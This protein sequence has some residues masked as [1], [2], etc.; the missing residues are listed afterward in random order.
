MR[1]QKENKPLIVRGSFK[2]QNS[3]RAQL[4]LGWL[5]GLWFFAP[6]KCMPSFTV[7]ITFNTSH[8]LKNTS[9]T[10]TT[11]LS[12][13]LVYTGTK[14][15]PFKNQFL[16]Q[17]INIMFW[18]MGL[19]FHQISITIWDDFKPTLNMEVIFNRHKASGKLDA[20]DLLV[21][22]PAVW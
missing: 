21:Q 17:L 7:I 1:P 22:S 3:G 19:I 11:L 9:V 2:W 8:W 18:N 14:I 16:F 5:Q 20:G 15:F 10:C 6:H 13:S 12:P 4:P